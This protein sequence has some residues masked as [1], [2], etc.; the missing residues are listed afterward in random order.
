MLGLFPWRGSAD[1]TAALTF[2]KRV[3]LFFWTV[4]LTESRRAAGEQ[5]ENIITA[6]REIQELIYTHTRTL[7]HTHGFQ[8]AATF[9]RDQSLILAAPNA[10]R[11]GWK[12]MKTDDKSLLSP[13][14]Q[15]TPMEIGAVK[16]RWTGGEQ[17]LTDLLGC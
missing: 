16:C 13:A 11:P 17:I 7:T 8:K 2:S 4:T 12:R 10:F 5:E 14:V 3:C 1:G 6:C 15:H 9:L